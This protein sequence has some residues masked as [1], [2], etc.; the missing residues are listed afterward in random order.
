MN[1]T[2]TVGNV[3][4]QTQAIDG[5]QVA[6]DFMAEMKKSKDYVWHGFRDC[7]VRP[8]LALS[9]SEP[10]QSFSKLRR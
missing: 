4:I 3:R 2:T 10:E 8:K 7:S 9:E 1:N 6:V 5:Q